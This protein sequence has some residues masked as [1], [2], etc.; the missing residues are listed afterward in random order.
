[1]RSL[2]TPS[3]PLASPERGIARVFRGPSLVLGLPVYEWPTPADAIFPRALSVYYKAESI[4]HSIPSFPGGLGG[5]ER[6]DI[7]PNGGHN[8]R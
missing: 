1:M 6:S 5:E 4:L 8:S 3:S 2:S 7:S